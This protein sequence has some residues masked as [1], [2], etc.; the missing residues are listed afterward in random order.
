MFSFKRAQY[1]EW[2][3]VFNKESK[4]TSRIPPKSWRI[5]ATTNV[6]YLGLCSS[7]D[8]EINIVLCSMSILNM[9]LKVLSVTS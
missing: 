3:W 8:I 2:I 1:S 7:V 9:L 5:I 4:Y 6:N